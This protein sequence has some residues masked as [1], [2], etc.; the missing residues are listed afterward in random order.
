MDNLRLMTERMVPYGTESNV[1]QGPYL[2]QNPGSPPQPVRL[3][4]EDLYCILQI[5][6]NDSLIAM[7]LARRLSHLGR[8]DEA[9]RILENVV[10][11]DY[12]FETLHALA[13]AA[14][15]LDLVDAAFEHMQHALLIA[16][17]DH[18]LLFD[19]FK[20]LGNLFVRRG[21][22]D[23]AEDSYNKAHRLNPS[24]D[25]L[26][27]NMGTLNMQ[28]QNWDE[29]VEK[30]RMAL[31]LNIKN[32]KAWVGLALGHRLK[33]DWELAWGNVEAALEINPLNE[34]ALTLALEWG[35]REGRE[36]RVLE[37]IRNYLVEGGWNEKLSLAFVWLSWKRGDLMVARLELERLLA[38]NPGHPQ[39]L[40]IA[41][42]M[43]S[44]H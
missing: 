19:A 13:Q 5:D 32:D 43:R 1:K 30:F 36:F 9:L 31:S 8:K 14:F 12:R 27:V 40:A 35:A 39:A 42:E 11:I 2:R 20:S 18:P 15:D 34:V 4:L 17:E 29:A 24:S 16:P 10:A 28:R 26:H 38:V 6:P 23:S 44:S 41:R 25:V 7:E 37:L 22:F 33:G 21:D 3:D